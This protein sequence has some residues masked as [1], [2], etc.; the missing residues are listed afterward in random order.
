MN[1]QAYAQ[2][3]K[4]FMAALELPA[5]R[6]STFLEESC[7]DDGIRAEVLL[8]LRNHTQRTLLT[9]ATQDET[10][11]LADLAGDTR[12]TSILTLARTTAQTI[13][14]KGRRFRTALV[15]G[16]MLLALLVSFWLY[17]GVRGSLREIR[18]QQLETLV[19]A[20][21][22]SLRHWI[23]GQKS[24]VAWWA[25]DPEF[26]VAVSELASI[27]SQPENEATLRGAAAQTTIRN[28]LQQVAGDDVE[29]SIWNRSLITISDGSTEASSAHTDC[30]FL[31]VTDQG[32]A[33]LNRVFEGNPVLQMPHIGEFI[34]RPSGAGKT[35]PSGNGPSLD[36]PAEKTAPSQMKEFEA[37]QPKMSVIVPVETTAGGALSA[38][39]LIRSS[40]LDD[41]F[42]AIFLAARAESSGETYAFNRAG[43]MISESRF[44]TQLRRIG[45]IDPS[46]ES[47]SR[48]VVQIRDPG[49]NLV[50][51]YQ[52]SV[53]VEARSLTK[54][55]AFA[56]AREDGSDVDGYRDYRG[57]PV[58]GAWRWLG[59]YDIG[60]TTEIDLAE[61][62]APLWYLKFAFGSIGGMLA[63]TIGLLAMSSGKIA[64][65]QQEVEEAQAND[66]KQ[67]GPYSLDQLIGQGGMGSVYLARHA[68]LKRPTA[69]KILDPEQAN[70]KT[71]AWF[72]REVQH[73]SQLSHPNTIQIYDYGHTPAGVFYY[74]MEYIDGVTLVD[75]LR[76]EGA[77]PAARVVHLI[78]Q[79]CLSLREAHSQNLIHR[80][81]KPQN[82]MVCQ[83]GGQGDV[84]KVLDFGLVKNVSENASPQLASTG[85]FFGT[86]LYMS[87]ERLRDPLNVD[88]RAD[89]Y[90]I[91]AVAFELLTAR[92]V[93]IGTSQADILDKAMNAKPERV[94]SLAPRPVPSELDDLIDACLAKDPNERPGSIDVILAVLDSLKCEG[95][96][97]ETDA[98]LYWE[99]FES[100]PGAE[101]VTFG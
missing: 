84:I 77:I 57:V 73:A 27:S 45:L 81:I 37:S 71:L 10:R 13:V 16:S 18:T 33:I 63:L 85:A 78:R 56:T 68:L 42:N 83:R 38:A 40:D 51:G 6:R 3:K 49:G 28:Y 15:A 67:V 39:L 59:E 19:E 1:P 23:N 26:R 25:R 21:Q 9:D 88:A 5:D 8:L 32:A 30:L 62:Y 98:L 82:I 65:L 55:A 14:P 52:T 70:S 41:E 44:N 99:R 2:V 64:K 86:P 93:F 91:G 97:G 17:T 7:D 4:L 54:M 87:P 43:E 61:A 80:D 69:V 72:E 92:P 76:L 94:S 12:K 34:R 74:A 48:L 20:E 46:P 36:K 79:V 75:L 60:I 24:K 101:T 53:P 47:I 11:S 90:A 31:G 89:I 29:F 66:E 96:W 22:A 50:E 35:M 58:I 100:G 95:R